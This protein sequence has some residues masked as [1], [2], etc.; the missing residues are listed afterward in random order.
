MVLI[1]RNLNGKLGEPRSCEVILKGYGQGK[2]RKPQGID[3]SR[4]GIEYTRY[5]A[6]EGIEKVPTS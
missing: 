5:L 2:S 6:R 1:E 4:S 3:S